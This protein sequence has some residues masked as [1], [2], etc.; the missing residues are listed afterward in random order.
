MFPWSE[1]NLFPFARVLLAF[2]SGTV[3]GRL[4]GFSRFANVIPPA[5]AVPR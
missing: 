5:G 1:G 2:W 4:H 3:R